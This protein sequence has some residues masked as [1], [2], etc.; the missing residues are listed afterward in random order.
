M[1]SQS[2]VLPAHPRIWPRRH[3]PQGEELADKHGGV[4]NETTRRILEQMLK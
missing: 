2:Q 3:V 1:Q 4:D